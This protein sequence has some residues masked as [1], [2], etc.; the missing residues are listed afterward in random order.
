[1]AGVCSL[2]LAPW[3]LWPQ[4][5]VQVLHLQQDVPSHQFGIKTITWIDRNASELHPATSTG[6]K[7]LTVL[8]NHLAGSWKGWRV[9]FSFSLSRDGSKLEMRH[10]KGWTKIVKKY[11]THLLR[12]S[13]SGYQK[14]LHWVQKGRFSLSPEKAAR[15]HQ[16]MS[17]PSRQLFFSVLCSWGKGWDAEDW[18]AEMH[19][20][21]M[22]V[23]T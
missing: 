14:G 18:D 21:L 6:Q 22:R 12:V 1:M 5:P 17:C 7:R 15:D 19:S 10:R 2:G 20:V 9:F 8:P 16:I 13:G 3:G 4:N 11:L 23:K